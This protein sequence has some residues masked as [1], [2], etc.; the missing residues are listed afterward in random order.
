MRQELAAV[1]A[2]YVRGLASDAPLFPHVTQHTSKMLHGD[3]EAARD[4]WLKESQTAE[5]CYDRF[6]SGV[7]SVKTSAG[8]VDFHALRHTFITKLARSGVSPAVAKTLARHSTITLTMDHYTHLRVEDT[9]AAL[10]ALRL[11]DTE[12]PEAQAVELRKTGTDSQVQY[13]VQYAGGRTAPNVAERGG[14]CG[15]EKGP[16]PE[17]SSARKPARTR[18]S[19]RELP[20]V[21]ERGGKEIDGAPRRT[22]TCNH[23]I[24]SQVLYQ[25]S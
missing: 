8:C 11:A 18:G 15:R 12:A 13:P 1:V 24:K 21:A 25:L 3:L 5:E 23:L 14:D 2:E 7:L 6:G 4:S 19:D 10:N 20:D 17:T 22:R 16:E 9:R